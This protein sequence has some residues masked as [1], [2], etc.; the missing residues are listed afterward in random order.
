MENTYRDKLIDERFARDKER[1]CS[2]EEHMEK[3]DKQ[4][5]DLEKLT[6]EMG[7]LIKKHDERLVDHG[8]RL[9]SIEERPAKNWGVV[10]TAAISAI[11]S[12]VVA[13][14]MALVLK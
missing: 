14:I 1:I 7:E 2:H 8:K 12:G 9:H 3:Q 13:A 5:N 10:Q 11:T 4:I 6:I